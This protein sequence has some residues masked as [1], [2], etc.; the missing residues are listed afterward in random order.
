MRDNIPSASVFEINTY[1][2]YN[3]YMHLIN[4][5]I[6]SSNGQNQPPQW[7]RV[8]IGLYRHQTFPGV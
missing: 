8:D 2:R 6:Q 7:I 1:I 4:S 3:R 5:Y